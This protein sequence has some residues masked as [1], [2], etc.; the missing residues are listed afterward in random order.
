[1]FNIY[2]ID[3]KIVKRNASSMFSLAPGAYIVNGKK[4]VVK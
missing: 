2:S 4:V 3:G 1:V